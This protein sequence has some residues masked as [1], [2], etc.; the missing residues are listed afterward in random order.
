MCKPIIK[1]SRCEKTFCGGFDYRMHFD[2]H[3]DEW[4]TSEDKKQYIKKTTQ[5]E[6]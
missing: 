4:Y 1:C 6:K 5:W 3:L 2:Q